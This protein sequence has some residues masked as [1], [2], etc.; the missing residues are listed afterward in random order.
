M[1]SEIIGQA[2]NLKRT[3]GRINLVEIANSYGIKVFSTDEIKAPSFIAYDPE[4]KGYEIYINSK[5]PGTRQ[6]FSIA[7]EL[8]HYILHRDKIISFGIVGRECEQSLLVLEERQADDLAANILMPEKSVID[9]LN[10]K[11]IDKSSLLTANMVKAVA[12]EFEVSL[13][14]AIL[15]LKKIGYYVEYIE[16]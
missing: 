13:M 11:G 3:K 4:T 16:V 1:K 6:R 10:S 7:H 8:A 15:R 9:Y 12:K 14:P 5:E 2:E